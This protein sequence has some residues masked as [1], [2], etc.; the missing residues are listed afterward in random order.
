MMMMNNDLMCTQKLTRSQLSLAYSAKV[1]TDIPDM[2]NLKDK[3]LLTVVWMILRRRVKS[4]PCC[5]VW[6]HVHD[7]R[8]CRRPAFIIY[9]EVNRCARP[10]S[11]PIGHQRGL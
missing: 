3:A 9:Y 8:C 11:W 10:S 2:S 5:R 4:P 7:V 6:S 1:K